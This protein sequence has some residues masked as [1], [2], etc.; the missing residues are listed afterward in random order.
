MVQQ[1]DL[2]PVNF[3]PATFVAG[4]LFEGNGTVVDESFAEWDYNGTQPKNIALK[5]TI[6]DDEGASVVQYWNAGLPS[7]YTIIEGGGRIAVPKAASEFV[8]NSTRVASLYKSLVDSG[9][10]STRITG[11]CH[12]DLHGLYAFWRRAKA[13]VATPKIFKII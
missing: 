13:E 4:G 8:I 5:L 7:K 12:K 1:S 11:D 2:K 3:D 9:F 10:P 6:V